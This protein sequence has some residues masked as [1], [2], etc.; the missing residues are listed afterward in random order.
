MVTNEEL[1]KVYGMF[2]DAWKFYKKYADVQQS[3]DWNPLVAE[4]DMITKKYQNNQLCRDL[5]VA[6]VGELER[7]S[8]AI[9]KMPHKKEPA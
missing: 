8:K 2:T 7:R 4:A 5:I 3:D 6:A 1:K 9:Q